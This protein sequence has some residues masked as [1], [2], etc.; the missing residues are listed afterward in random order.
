MNQ[1]RWS[2]LHPASLISTSRSAATPVL[3][4]I[5]DELPDLAIVYSLLHSHASMAHG[6]AAPGS[7]RRDTKECRDAWAGRLNR[8]PAGITWLQATEP[9]SGSPPGA[10]IGSCHSRAW[11][12]QIMWRMKSSGTANVGM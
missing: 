5:S 1:Q 2:F 3:P 9:G 8:E 7:H 4:A 6:K 12:M 10:R 11:A